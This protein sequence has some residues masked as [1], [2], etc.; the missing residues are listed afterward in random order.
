M[1][2]NKEEKTDKQSTKRGRVSSDDHSGRMFSTYE[3][4]SEVST[5]L[6]TLP[7]IQQ[8]LRDISLRIDKFESVNKAIIDLKSELWDN[9]GIDDRLSNVESITSSNTDSVANLQIENSQLKREI[10]T[11]KSVVIRLDRKVTSQENEINN[12]KGRSMRDNLLI[13]HFRESPEEN[14]SVTVPRAIKEH[15]GVDV[16]FIRIHRN[17]PR[18]NINGKPRSITGKLKDFAKK[19]AILKEQKR[20]KD[21]NKELPFHITP[22]SPAPVA[23]NRKKLQEISYSYRQNNVKHRIVGDKIIFEN[24][25]ILK[26]KVPVPSA[27]DILS[28]DTNEFEKLEKLHSVKTN[29]ITENGNVFIANGAK[30]STFTEVRNIYKKIVSDPENSRATHRILAFRFTDNNG[31]I[32]E[33]YQDDGEH[34]AGRKLL[35]YM[36]ENN[37]MNMS[38]VVLRWFSGKHIGPKRFSI[39]ESLI[40]EAS[41]EL[42]L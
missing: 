20:I 22:Q 37:L 10:N 4:P 34:G 16:E 35:K 8:Q 17:S 25:S 32:H 3:L 39:M 21:Q 31:K 24:G 9:E 28:I 41:R 14:L 40:S 26:D 7:V 1:N 15:L 11:L 30:T 36:R 29:S 38:F 2:F 12:L 42:Y 27:E 18:P 6:S 19:D 33:N 13:H 5:A 23:E